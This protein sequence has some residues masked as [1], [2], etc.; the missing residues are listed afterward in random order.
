[1]SSPG[2]AA[3][4]NPKGKMQIKTSTKIIGLLLALL[5]VT[6]AHARSAVILQLEAAQ[7][8]AEIMTLKSMITALQKSIS[9]LQKQSS[10][11]QNTD[12][13]QAAI[14]AALQGKSR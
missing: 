14:F 3:T 10:I 4:L 11:T 7:P 13:T 5:A 6:C 8:Q 1:M 2:E 9:T 12:P